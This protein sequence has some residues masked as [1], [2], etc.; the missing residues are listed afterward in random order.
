MGRP[1]KYD[2][3]FCAEIIA[4]AKKGGTF[5]EFAD[6]KNVHTE[7]LQEWKRKHPDFSVAWK[8]AKQ[9]AEMYMVRL[10]K[11]AML[12][13]HIGK[14]GGTKRYLNVGVWQYF[15]ACRFGWRADAP[16]ED[17]DNDLEFDF[18]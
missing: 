1:S 10:G 11:R 15:M 13:K 12:G 5:E 17:D 8:R 18:E 4:H 9:L 3:A 6:K 7:T 16:S 14:T 2:P